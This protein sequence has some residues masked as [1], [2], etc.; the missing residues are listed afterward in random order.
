MTSPSSIAS[1]GLFIMLALTLMGAYLDWT[2]DPDVVFPALSYVAMII[3]TI[4]VL[5]IGVALLVILFHSN[6]QGYAEPLQP[7]K[8]DDLKP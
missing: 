5:A 3:G 2:L 7:K 4:F 8:K 1:V 6:N